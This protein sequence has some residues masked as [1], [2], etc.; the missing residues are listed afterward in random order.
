MKK[1]LT[2]FLFMISSI[3]FAQL[4]NQNMHVIANKN[5]FPIPPQFMAPW[6]YAAIWGYV[7][8]DGREY[9]ILGAAFGPAFYDVTDSSDVRLVGFFHEIDSLNPDQGNLWREMKVY[10]H[11]AYVVS[12]AQNSG[13]QIYD[14]QYLPDSV[15]HV[16]R[17][18]ATN[19]SST[20]SISQD[21]PYLYLNGANASFGNGT[22][23]LDLSVDPENPV[24]RGSWNT[25]YV[26]D[27][28]IVDD[29]IYATCINDGYLSVIDATNKDSLKL[30]TEWLNNPN[31]SPHNSA[32]T[33]D[34]KYIMTTDEVGA[35]PRLLKIW[36]IEDLQ[37]PIQVD[38]WQPPG[39]TT[40]RVH[41]IEIYGDT[42]VIAHYTA[43]VYVLDISDPENPTEIAWYDTYPQNNGGAFQGCWGVYKFPSGKIIASDMTRGLFVLGLGNSVGISNNNGLAEGFELKQ[44]YP[45]PF[46]PSTE[47]TFSIPKNSEVTLKV[48]DVNGKEVAD[49][50]N[51]NYERGTHSITFDAAKFE[52]S[53][54]IYFYTLTAGDLKETKKMLL[55]K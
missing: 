48:Y 20:H 53:S 47:I 13:V 15:H 22:V 52:L 37:D 10:S 36:N 19:H 30:V 50:I 21:G 35:L 29:T 8:P 23:V 41:N 32:L 39:I 27:S 49:L 45:N 5:D 26:H 2:I 24:L 34:K 7:A 28:R 25:R 11:Y 55:V 4:P 16:Q 43:G 17:F 40:A 14:L 6:S 44:N 33:T 18:L 46:N 12:E 31:P 38:T 42:A 1:I 54:G 3:S 9:A 51:K